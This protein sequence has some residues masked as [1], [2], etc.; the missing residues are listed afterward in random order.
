MMEGH[1]RSL[2]C[3]ILK[4]LIQFQLWRLLGLR[5][6]LTGSRHLRIG[7]GLD[8][9]KHLTVYGQNGDEGVSE[10]FK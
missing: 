7:L 1:K 6:D 2:A 10:Q 9:M 8:N 4:A 5:L 3:S